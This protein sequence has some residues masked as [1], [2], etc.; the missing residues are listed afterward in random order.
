M[1]HIYRARLV[2]FSFVILRGYQHVCL[3][4]AR[5]EVP[6]G[7]LQRGHQI[8]IASYR[9]SLSVNL[10]DLNIYLFGLLRD[11]VDITEG[12]STADSVCLEVADGEA[13]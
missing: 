9:L 10:S 1:Q 12:H 5:F 3:L 13:S 7:L 8:C 2:D 11:F 4:N 6:L